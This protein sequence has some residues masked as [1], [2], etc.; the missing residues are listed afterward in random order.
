MAVWCQFCFPFSSL[1]QGSVVSVSAAPFNLTSRPPRSWHWS[2]STHTGYRHSKLQIR[3]KKK[4]KNNLSDM[5]PKLQSKTLETKAQTCPPFEAG[6]SA[7]AAA[8]S[9]GE[10]VP[11]RTAWISFQDCKNTALGLRITKCAPLQ[12][13]RRSFSLQSRRGGA[14]SMACCHS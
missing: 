3:E 2:F 1:P 6:F 4:K 7:E 14:L 10:D 12:L 8:E 9:S 11:D 5:A 13:T